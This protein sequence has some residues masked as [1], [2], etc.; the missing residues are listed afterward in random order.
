MRIRNQ[1]LLTLLGACLVILLVTS[2][3]MQFSFQRSLDQYL[4][5]RQHALLT[6]LSTE[7]SEY[8]DH[9]GSFDG[10]TL[11]TLI[12]GAEGPSQPHI[13]P[14]LILLDSARAPIF[15][16]PIP[17]DEL[18]LR[19]IKVSG[20]TVGWLGLPNSPE[21]R[22]DIEH[23]FARKQRNLLLSIASATLCLAFIGAWWLSRKL[24][25]PIEA[26]A[27]FSRTLRDG[28]FKQR[29]SGSFLRTQKSD[30]L[31][32]LSSSMNSLAHSLEQS[33]SSRQ[34][35]LADLSHE[36]R[37]PVTVMRAELEAMQDGVRP[38]DQHQINAVLSETLHLTK[39]LDDLHDLSLADVGAL[40][41]R[42]EPINFGDIVRV[43]CASYEP[44]FSAKQQQLIFHIP[45]TPLIQNGDAVRLRQL[46]DNLL[47]NALKYTD[48]GTNVDVSLEQHAGKIILSIKDDSPGV[49]DEQLAHLFDHLYR[50]ENSRNRQTGGAGLG[51][52]ICQRIVEAH[53]GTIKAHHNNV[54]ETRGLAIEIH[55]TRGGKS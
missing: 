45:S 1:F 10:I 43:S 48:N 8:Y 35:W 18:T 4:S 6:E 5:Q 13:P 19:V 54:G 25:K 14:D 51:L 55:F 44:L 32:Q 41:Y 30:E 17:T 27:T 40:R 42:M 53:Q 36:L 52:A 29:L 46:L 37:T 28:D 38:L 7:F 24:V 15:G 39:L 3:L 23:R 33:H 50:V 16:P 11:R 2:V 34:R 20:E 12:W 31:K 22:A 21:A 47:S 26:V 9:Y 49:S